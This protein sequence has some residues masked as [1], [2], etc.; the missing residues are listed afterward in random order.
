[1]SAAYKRKAN[2]VR[3]VN[4]ASKDGLNLKGVAR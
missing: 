4:A 1:M 3:L 2:K